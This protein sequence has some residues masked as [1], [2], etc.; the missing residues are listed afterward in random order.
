MQ[1]LDDKDIFGRMALISNN[2]IFNNLRNA[3]DNYDADLTDALSWG[4]LKSKRWLINEL[5][6]LKAD[7]GT[8]FLCGGWYATLAAMLFESSLEIEKIRSFDIDE[9]C[10]AIAETV[11]RHKVKDGWKFKA[12]TLDILKMDY[13]TTHTT[14]RA[15]GTSMDLKEMPNTIINTSCEHI[16]NFSKWFDKIPNNT[17]VILQSNDY[18]EIEEHINCV[19]D[20]EDF[21]K[22][23]PLTDVLY[24]G[25]LELPKY[26]RFMRIGFK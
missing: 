11:N 10:S 3:V 22:M 14:Y 13:P 15:D 6:N 23:A 9:S 16:E 17:L 4:Q 20:E 8:V 12:S 2:P 7:L 19:V 21:A 24:S 26:T 18:F 5:E 1:W 25:R